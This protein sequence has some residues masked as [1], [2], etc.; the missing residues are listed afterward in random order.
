MNPIHFVTL[1]KNA[2]DD[3]GSEYFKNCQYLN[4][5]ISSIFETI[6]EQFNKETSSK[7]LKK[8]SNILMR[9]KNIEIQNTKDLIRIIVEYHNQ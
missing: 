6:Y 4:D 1:S 5:T 7:K 3:L 2:T 8:W 9:F